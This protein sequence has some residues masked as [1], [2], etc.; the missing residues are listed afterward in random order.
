[1]GAKRE[2]IETSLQ[3]SAAQ[4]GQEPVLVGELLVVAAVVRQKHVHDGARDEHDDGRQQ[5]REPKLG[6]RD[7]AQSPF[8]AR[9]TVKNFPPIPDNRLISRLIAQSSLSPPLSV[10]RS[11]LLVLNP[12]PVKGPS[13]LA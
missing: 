9:R 1:V 13:G 5:D 4:C 8:G 12:E 6:E 7:H 11:Q 10:H 2:N 3:T